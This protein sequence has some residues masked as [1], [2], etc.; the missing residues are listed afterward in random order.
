MIDTTGMQS[1]AELA[2]SMDLEAR[3]LLEL[4]AEAAAFLLAHRWCERVEAGFLARVWPGI[5]AVFLYRILPRGG[6]DPE[7]WVIVGDVP[8]AY[9]DVLECR[10]AQ[11]ALEAYTDRMLEWVEQ[12]KASGP[13]DDCIPV[14]RRGSLQRVEPTPALIERLEGRMWFI[15]ERLLPDFDG[16]A[17]N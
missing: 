7:L 6:A 8:P 13:L 9:I 15:R 4:A 10:T 5:L 11:E 2:S 12:A 17:G 14:Y 16:D 1:E 3:E